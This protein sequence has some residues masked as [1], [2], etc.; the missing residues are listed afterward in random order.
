MK[1]R[2]LIQLTIILASLLLIISNVFTQWIQTNLPDSLYT[3]S[4]A[5]ADSLI[6]AGTGRGVFVTT[7]RGVNWKV[8][9]TGLERRLI[10]SLTY[11]GLKM[12]AGTDS[13][14]FI[15]NDSIWLKVDSGKANTEVN[16]MVA[17]ETYILAGMYGYPNGILRSTNHGVTWNIIDSESYYIRSITISDSD[18]YVGTNT[19]G[20]FHSTDS[21]ISWQLTPLGGYDVRSITVND[22]FLFVATNGG[23]FRSSD[24]G[25]SW[26]AV[27]NGLPDT[28]HSYELALA[29]IKSNIFV[30]TSE[31]FIF[32]STNDGMNWIRTNY[33]S[34][35]FNMR[36]MII[37]D[38]NI[39]V[40][41]DGGVWRCP[42]SEL[43]I[44]AQ[45]D[46]FL[47]PCKYSLNQNYPNP[48]NPSTQINFFVPKAIDV[49]LKVYDVLGREIAVLVNE[50]KQHGEYNV[51]WNV[52]GVPSGVYFYRIVAGDFIQTKKMVVVK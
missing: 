39:F 1:L 4:I 46:S 34:P 40:C 21:G 45:S 17:T 43:W 9:S 25:T 24:K 3:Y 37:N 32:L 44:S 8:I 23:V 12:F 28:A 19:Q 5:V 30:G 29:S 35:I 7:D 51:T 48:F 2:H 6:F 42:L 11:D 14:I 36:A 13:G 27:V 16:A 33:G 41:G 49:T 15:L 22:S 18:I 20:V 26:E 10:W 31:G 52:E 38:S 50:R 47:F